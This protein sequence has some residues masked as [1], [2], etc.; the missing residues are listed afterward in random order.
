MAQAADG[1]SNNFVPAL[2]TADGSPNWQSAYPALVWALYTYYGDRGAAEAHHESLRRYYDH[3]EQLYRGSANLTAY[4]VG[5]G[6]WVSAGP[7]GNRHLISAFA[8]LRDLQMGADFFGGSRA[9]GA[10][11]Q[12][13][14]CRTLLAV[15]AAAFHSAFFDA[16]RGYYGSGLQTEQVLPLRLGIVP[17]PL[18]AQV[19]AYPVDD[20]VRTHGRHTTSGILG[21]KAA[22]E[23]LS[24]AG[25]TDVVLAMLAEDGYPSYGYMLRGG[26]LG[27][28]PATTLWELWDADVQGPGMNS[29]NHI[30]FG[31]VGSWMYKHLLGVTPLTPG[32][33]S[34]GV[35]PTGVLCA[36]CNLTAAAG[37]VSTPYGS[38]VVRWLKSDATPP[39]VHLSVTIPLGAAA[40]IGVPAASGAT[41]SEGGRVAW[42]G[43]AFVPG[44]RGITSAAAVLGAEPR[45]DFRVASGTYIFVSG[46]AA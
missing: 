5:F 43:G 36:G 20:I 25:R 12:A 6:D 10:A 9:A 4:P 42:R 35:R 46:R 32:F 41:I 38:V 34:V 22:F 28:E 26:K 11:A 29:R 1:G 15:A 40:T 18:K 16:A 17:E 3:L 13:A 14:R 24:A 45:V 19:L 7:M 27:A 21:I 2:G 33:A 8:L 39:T 30:M 31:T 44:V 23:V 37:A